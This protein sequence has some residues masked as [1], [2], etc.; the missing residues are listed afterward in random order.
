MH[1]AK[2]VRSILTGMITIEKFEAALAAAGRDL[3]FDPEEK[4]ALGTVHSNPYYT[5]EAVRVRYAE[6]QQPLGLPAPAVYHLTTVPPSPER[7]EN[8]Y[9]Y[10]KQNLEPVGLDVKKTDGGVAILHDRGNV[11]QMR[12]AWDLVLGLADEMK[13]PVTIDS[14]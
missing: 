3:E 14:K 11:H 9:Q 5:D 8:T 12:K 7:L 2:E 10:L 6:L 4:I 1:A 13:V